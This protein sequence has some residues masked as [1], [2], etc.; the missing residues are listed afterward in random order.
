MGRAPRRAGHRHRERAGRR[1]RL[2]RAGILPHRSSADG[3]RGRGARARP[4]HGYRGARPAAA[5]Y[6]DVRP[7]R[8]A[9]AGAH[10]G[11]LVRPDLRLR[12]DALQLRLQARDPARQPAGGG[13]SGVDPPLVRLRARASVVRALARR[14]VRQHRGDSARHRQSG[15]AVR[16][17]QSFR[18]GEGRPRLRRQHLEHDRAAGGGPGHGPAASGR[19]RSGSS[20]S[21]RRNRDSAAARSS[22]AGR[23]RRGTASSARSTTT[24]SGG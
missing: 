24:W 17:G 3:H 11:D 7:D 22:S 12:A 18:F 15:V 10:R 5:G 19:P 21:P 8:S 14:P 6:G 1:H 16:G 13:V 20:G 4:R 23:P 9:G 2:A